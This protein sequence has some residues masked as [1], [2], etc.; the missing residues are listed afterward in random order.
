MT[1]SHPSATVR[2]TGW[3][4]WNLPARLRIYVVGV[5]LL[6]AVAV[7]Y[8]LVVNP[9][10]GDDVLTFA[11]LLGGGAAAVESRRRLGEPAGVQMHDVLSAW[12][13]PT[14]VLLPPVYALLAPVVL[15]ALSQWRVRTLVVHRR[16]FSAAAIGLAYAGSSVMFHVL[17]ASAGIDAPSRR[18][19]IWALLSIACGLLAAFLN[20]VLVSVAV[21][22]SDPLSTWRQLLWDRD[23]AWL[24][25][26]ELSAGLVV[27]LAASLS[28]VLVFAVLPVLVMLHRSFMHTQLSA[29]A[30]L[31]GKTGLLNAVTWEREAEAELAR[32][33]RT[34]QSAAVL[35]VDIDLFKAVNDTYGHLIGDEVLVAVADAMVGEL[36]EGDL[37][38]R[39]GGEEFAVLLP[40]ADEAEARRA[41]ERLR[42]RVAGLTVSTPDADAVR[43]TISVG[44]SIA[45]P[46]GLS[47]AELL[48]AADAGLY[49]AKATGRNRVRL[50]HGVS[51]SA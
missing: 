31:D 47:V 14:M 3:A 30:R 28:G 20:A 18:P 41:A 19:L 13:L 44:A 38:G 2:V 7:L 29:A 50:R 32:L 27:A 12:W 37:I 43:V 9:L 22:A 5:S 16:V 42:S 34:R 25:I 21:K 49:Q 11:V 10:R 26:V 23:E 51:G 39:F 36:R 15:L 46:P 8:G 24:D 48:A 35:L 40:T 45:E 4:V 17:A 1:T 6:A 33:H